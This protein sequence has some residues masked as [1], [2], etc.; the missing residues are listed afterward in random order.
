[1]AEENNR[2]NLERTE[3]PTPRRREEARKQGQFPRSRELIP[4]ATLL[5]LLIFMRWAG[6]EL[7]ERHARLLAAFL[8]ASGSVKQLGVQDISQFLL[9]TGWLFAPVILPFFAAAVLSAVGCGVLQSGMVLAAEPIR[10]DFSRI[11][12]SNG[13]RRLF[14]IDA[15]ADLTKAILFIAALGFI[16]G[17]LIYGDLPAISSLANMA[18]S[19]ILAVTGEE[20]KSVATWI[21]CTVGGLAALDYM[22]Q[23]RRTE[24]K[25]RMSRQEVKE[26]M[27]EQEGDPL[28]KS[29]LKNLRQKLSRRRI[30]S[31]VAKADVVI[32]NPTELAIALRYRAGEMHAPKVLGKGAGFIA[33][34]IREVARANSIPIVE[35]KPLA[36]LLYR[37]VEIGREIP[38]ALYRAV[39]ETL[40]YVYRLR[41]GGSGSGAQPIRPKV[42]EPQEQ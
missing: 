15:L 41:R 29:Q 23:R 40:A 24:T 30:M 28:V 7:I 39:A 19:D 25:L 35:N 16:G 21:I 18:V 22:F 4:A 32:T 34:K 42:S 26:D 13:L 27:R 38:E 1:M 3:E 33:Q 11:N 9:N 2:D 37:E 36:R 6:G 10:L 5:V 31:D 14:S 8:S 12:P 20:A 17:K